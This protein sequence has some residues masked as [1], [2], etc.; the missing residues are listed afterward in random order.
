MGLIPKFMLPSP[1]DVVRALMKEF[2][3]LLGH[4]LVSL[5]ESFIGLTLSMVFAFI[6]AITMDRYKLVHRAV[7]P[8][9]IIS[10]TIPVIAIAPLLVLWMGYGIAP[11][12][13]LIFLV[14]FFPIVIALLEGFKAA[15]RDT[16]RLMRSMGAT[17][18]QILVHIKFPCAL[19]GLFAGLKVSVSYA[20]IG[21]VIAEWLGGDK[22]LG[23]YMTR[24][25]KSY[26][27]DKMFAVI[28]LI[29]ILS[30]LLMKGVS[31]IERKVTPWNNIKN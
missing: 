1:L 27:F 17:Q 2:Y 9:F 19:G 22:G 28:L 30:L 13:F 10:Q 29:S 31:Y 15:D 23:V 14:C 20:I 5:K 18:N 8:L 3:V 6:M 12:I 11:K 16:I 4:T 7:Y 24:V 25:R 21:A 26:A